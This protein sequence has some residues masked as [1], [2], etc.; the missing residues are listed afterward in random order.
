MA[1]HIKMCKIV[2]KI[3]SLLSVLDALSN[4]RD[5]VIKFKYIAILYVGI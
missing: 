5:D 3:L 4:S 1:A 2:T